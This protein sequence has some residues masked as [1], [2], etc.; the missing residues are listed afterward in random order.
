M[1]T[2]TQSPPPDERL[3]R[4]AAARRRQ[5]VLRRRARWLA[6]GGVALLVLVLAIAVLGS[7]GGGRR[8]VAVPTVATGKRL[9]QIDALARRRI[10]ADARA[11]VRVLGYT[12]FVTSGG[13]RKREVALTFDDGP[14]PY[15]G[16]VLRVLRRAGVH[17]TFFEVGYMERWF[18]QGTARAIHEGH[19]IGDHTESHPK[20]ARLSRVDQRQQIEAQ[21]Q[22]LNRLGLPRSRLFRP[23]YGSFDANTF[24]L[25]RRKGM[26]MVLWSVDSEDYR[27]PG[28]GAIVRNVLGSVRPGAIVLMHDAGGNRSQTVAALPKIIRGLRQRN[29]RIVTVPRLLLDDPPPRDQELP[30]YLTG[31]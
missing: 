30:H 19:S 28:V 4:R 9:Q 10:A 7:G 31:G 1:S 18:H 8:A 24:T 26:L 2:A 15:T 16:K 29:Y 20:L 11:V 17:A 25:L 22:W 13:A 12:P 23:P 3:Q 27:Q 5:V 14:G 6:G 21:E